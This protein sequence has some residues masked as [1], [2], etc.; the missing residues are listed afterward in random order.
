ML[1]GAAGGFE[2]KVENQVKALTDRREPAAKF[3][4]YPRERDCSAADVIA[5]RTKRA[6]G[7]LLSSPSPSPSPHTAVYF[8]VYR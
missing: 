7:G 4:L 2:V 5:S 3:K 6:G 8:T 1:C